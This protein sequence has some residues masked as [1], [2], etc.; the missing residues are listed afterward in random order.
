MVVGVA[1]ALAVTSVL[2]MAM[3]GT[4]QAA[5]SVSRAEFSLGQ[6]SQNLECGPRSALSYLLREAS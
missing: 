5:V 3:A 4:A 1:V 6:E 2:L